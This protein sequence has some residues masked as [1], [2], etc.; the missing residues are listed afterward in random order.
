MAARARRHPAETVS[1][2]SAATST[3]EFV[4]ERHGPLV[5]AAGLGGHGFAH[6]PQVGE[7]VAALATDREPAT[8]GG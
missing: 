5:V 2:T 7:T 4:L 8:V 6:A 1:S 3:G